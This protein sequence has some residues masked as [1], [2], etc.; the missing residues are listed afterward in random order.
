[1]TR[2]ETTI[3]FGVVFLFTLYL[4]GWTAFQ[5]GVDDGLRK[6]IHITP[7]PWTLMAGYGFKG[8]LD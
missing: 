5:V 3:V 7:L 8:T 6:P 2:P 1:M 4:A